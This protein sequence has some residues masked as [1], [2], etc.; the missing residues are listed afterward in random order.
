MQS[1]LHVS[2][3]L[4]MVV[5]H[6]LAG[7]GEFLVSSRHALLE[8]DIWTERADVMEGMH[9]VMGGPGNKAA[10]K[11]RCRVRVTGVQPDDNAAANKEAVQ[12][13]DGKE[14]E[15]VTGRTRRAQTGRVRR[16][17]GAKEPL[18]VADGE[19]RQWPKRL[20]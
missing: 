2:I 16:E 13:A 19:Q 6:V 3:R 10:R 7:A 4:T 17:G 5:S 1:R 20:A 15:V 18:V 12:R 9:D 8:R 11:K 14:K